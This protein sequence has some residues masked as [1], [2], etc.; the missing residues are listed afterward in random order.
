MTPSTF[1]LQETCDTSFANMIAE[2]PY[3]NPDHKPALARYF[4]ALIEAGGSMSVE[5]KKKL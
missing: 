4:T 2:S 5:Y 1:T 3:V